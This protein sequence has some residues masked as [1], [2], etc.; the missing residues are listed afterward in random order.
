MIQ[1]NRKEIRMRF[2]SIEKAERMMKRR[3]RRRWG[4]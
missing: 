3:A 1:Y 4:K 2:M